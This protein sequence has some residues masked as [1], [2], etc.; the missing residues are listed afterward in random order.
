VLVVPV[1][2][3]VELRNSDS[4]VH[5]VHS[6]AVKNSPFNEAIPE[7]GL[8]LIKRFD[9]VEIVRLGCELHQEMAAWIVVRDNPYYAL[10]DKDGHFSIIEIPPGTYQLLLW[11]EDL[12][13]KERTS[14]A[15][16]VNVEPNATLEVDFY[17]TPKE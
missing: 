17:L 13:K 12:D 5:N 3:T 11:H 14:F 4:E 10:T 7:G 1:G 9:R 16:E 2:A 6:F 15:T 8:P